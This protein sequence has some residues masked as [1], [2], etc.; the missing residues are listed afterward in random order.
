MALQHRSGGHKPHRR[1][2][3][4]GEQTDSWVLSRPEGPSGKTEIELIPGSRPELIFSPS[5]SLHR[6]NNFL[7]G[8]SAVIKIII[9]CFTKRNHTRA[10]VS[11]VRA[12]QRSLA[13]IKEAR[14][15]PADMTLPAHLTLSLFMLLSDSP[16]FLTWPTQHFGP[17]RP[18]YSATSVGPAR[19]CSASSRQA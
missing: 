7:K 3:Q 13:E 10:W 12:S 1:E 19:R 5:L 15:F 16:S 17:R 9:F 6:L 2:R 8:I 4:T 11:C 14:C 18:N